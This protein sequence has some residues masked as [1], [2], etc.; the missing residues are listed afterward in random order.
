MGFFVAVRS[1]GTLPN[2]DKIFASSAHFT[3]SNGRD[4]G[5]GDS[6]HTSVTVDL[7]LKR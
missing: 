7:T 4:S 5:R 3:A 2:Y 1:R 6:D